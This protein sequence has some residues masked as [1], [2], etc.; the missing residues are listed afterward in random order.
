[1]TYSSSSHQHFYQLASIKLSNPD[2]PGK[3]VVKMEN[4]SFYL[5]ALFLKITPL[6]Q[7]LLSLKEEP[8]RK[9][10]N[11][12]LSHYCYTPSSPS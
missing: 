1:M 7:V 4:Q 5:T 9:L 3:M 11:S 8:L 2:S 6:A 12:L 10:P